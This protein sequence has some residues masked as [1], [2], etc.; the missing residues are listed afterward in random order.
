MRNLRACFAL[1]MLALAGIMSSASARMSGNFT[2]DDRD[3]LVLYDPP[4]KAWYIH[5]ARD[6]FY[7]TG[8]R[9]GSDGAL[10]LIGDVDGD[11]QSDL[12][13]YQ[14]ADGVW[15]IYRVDGSAIREQVTFGLT[16][17][18]PFMHDYNGDGH[19]DLGHYSPSSGAW[20]V[21]ALDGT[22]LV[23][24][25]SLGIADA[26]PVP[27]DY[28][29]DGRADLAVYQAAMGRWYV[30]TVEGRQIAWNHSWGFAG[31]V[32]VPGD[33]DGDGLYDLAIFNPPDGRWYV[34][35]V[36]GAVLVWGEQSGVP[37]G[38][39]MSGRFGSSGGRDDLVVY[40]GRPD[41]AWRIISS[42]MS[43]P[44]EIQQDGATAPLSAIPVG[45][46][47]KP[48]DINYSEVSGFN[49]FNGDG[50]SDLAVYVPASGHW[51]IRN[52]AGGTLAWARSW[53][54]SGAWPVAADY[55]GDGQTD[56]AVYDPA[57]GLWHIV[58]MEGTPYHVGLAWGFPGTI[59]VPADYDGDG[60]A[61]L[62]VYD[63]NAGRWYVWSF[64]KSEPLIWGQSW[65][66]PG[67]VR[68]WERPPTRTVLPVPYDYDADG[69]TD[70]AV[71]Y[72]GYSMNDSGW[73][74]LGSLG[75]IWQPVIWGS[76]GSIPAPGRYRTSLDTD[77]YPEGI[78]TYKVKY[79][80]PNDGTDGTFNTPY[81]GGNLKVG[82][83][84]R[85]LPVA[86]HD[87]T[88]SGFDDH[89]VYDYL[90]GIWTI[91]PGDG[92]GNVGDAANPNRVQISWGFNGAIPADM[93][94]TI[95]RLSGYGIR[96]W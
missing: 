9:L 1:V 4:T 53:G 51:Y 22:I 3:D 66:W 59:P 76:S 90:A 12:A 64:V 39:P 89:A 95:L 83:Y 29:G 72:R 55:D 7:D 40:R 46:L 60:A 41:A 91:V 37:R 34:R 13:V 17:C 61:D 45:P 21:R 79:S 28:N 67:D 65:G 69:K 6:G 58:G 30:R 42:P 93:Y 19:D 5:D 70:L 23:N 18:I 32:A 36:A 80:P 43:T 50:A 96:P 92:E 54:Y 74:V 20:D 75:R 2:G 25:V 24:G 73:Y 57:R 94:S 52:Y 77:R 85:T 71:Y 48:G 35:N 49:D 81:I 15:S 26:Q 56:L 44:S 82:T 8:L 14:P 86:A 47:Y 84:G 62:A 31:T 78:T 33:H 88:G 10:P 68:P 27:G 38:V 11:G 87:F 16:G 63:P